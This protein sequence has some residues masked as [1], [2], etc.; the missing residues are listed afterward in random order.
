[1]DVPAA[2]VAWLKLVVASRLA[3]LKSFARDF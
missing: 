1:M 2:L 3:G